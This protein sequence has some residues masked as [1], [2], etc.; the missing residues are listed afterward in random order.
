MPMALVFDEEFNREADSASRE[1][2]LQGLEANMNR[3]SG[4]EN[5]V[6]VGVC[7]P[8]G[9]AIGLIIM[10]W[11]SSFVIGVILSGIVFLMVSFLGVDRQRTST[12]R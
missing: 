11:V 10:F 2:M 3:D 8:L 5:V 1:S 9:N 6:I 12:R 7:I 4:P